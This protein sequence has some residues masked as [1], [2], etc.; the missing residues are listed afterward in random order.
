VFSQTWKQHAWEEGRHAI[1]FLR[2]N[3]L[4]DFSSHQ[5]GAFGP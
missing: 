5:Q 4:A 1:N 2:A 3:S